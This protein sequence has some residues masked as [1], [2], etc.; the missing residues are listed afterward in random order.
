MRDIRLLLIG[1]LLAVLLLSSALPL[2]AEVSG[3]SSENSFY[4]IILGIIEDP[5]PIPTISWEPVLESGGEVLNADGAQ[6]NDGRPDVAY[7]PETGRPV[8]TWAYS[9]GSDHDV[10]VNEWTGDSWGE[11]TYLTSSAHDELD[12]RAHVDAFGETY[13]VWW[14][15]GSTEKIYLVSREAGADLWKNPE[16]VINGGRRPSVVRYGDDIAIAYERDRAGGGQ[17]IA[18]AYL[19]AD[20]GVVEELVGETVR[21]DP[22]DAMVHYNGGL[23][24]VDWK[25]SDDEFAYSVLEEAG[26]SDATTVAWTDHSWVGE[27]VMRRV[28]Q[29]EVLFP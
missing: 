23:L 21:T 4:I 2:R 29:S 19:D 13:V 10:A 8:V 28:I 6:R 9:A 26:W 15:S 1:G 27:E 12:P 20:G 3:D 11:N 14:K 16:R 24:W 25:H 22:L 18:I 5:D 17:E 7:H